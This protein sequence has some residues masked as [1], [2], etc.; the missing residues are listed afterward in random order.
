VPRVDERLGGVLSEIPTPIIPNPR[1]ERLGA[2]DLRVLV[3][4]ILLGAIGVFVAWHYYFQAFPEASINFQVSRDEALNRAK[5]FLTLQGAS[6]DGYESTI[7]FSVDDNV[8]T[9]LERTVGLEQANKLMSTEVNA[10]H[11]EIR[12]F[13]P[14]QKEEFRAD[15]N[16]EG[17]IVGYE[18]I[19]E[20]ARAGASLERE[21]AQSLAAKYLDAQYGADL[22]RYDFL[23]EESNPTERPNRRDW[24]F[25]WQLRGFRAPDNSDGAP[26]RINVSVLG[27]K[28]G[29]A[30]EFLK[31]PEAWQRDFQRMRS[32]NDL[33]ESIAI[34]P[35]MLLL[36]AAFWFIFELS[37]RGAMRWSSPLWIGIFFALLWF[38]MSISNWPEIR[39]GYD[40]NSSY[41]AF[42]LGQIAYAE[43]LSIVQALLVTIAVA[44]GEPL[45]RVSQPSRIQL[46]KSWKLPGL[47]SK[48]FFTAGII[49]VSLAAI[50]IGYVVVF[51]LVGKHVG[52]WAPQDVNFDNST[53]SI[54][55]WLGALA[56]GMYAAASE[57]F[58]F[59]LFAIPF[60]HRV[61][62]SKVIAV[63]LPA[64]MWSFLHSNYPQEPAYIRGIEIGIIGIVAGLVML[65][66]GILATLVW[67]Y[68]VDATLGSLLLL[69]SA[70]PYLRI[71]GALVAGAAFIPLA[72][73]AV[74]YFKRGGFEVRED[75]LNSAYPLPAPQESEAPTTIETVA[76]TIAAGYQSIPR[77]Y[78][79]TLIVC[80][81]A[82]IAIIAS[83]HLQ[84]VGDYAHT[85]MDARQAAAA[86]DDVMQKQ[87]VNLAMYHRATIFLSNLDSEGTD[88][89]VSKIG[90]EKTN[91]IYQQQIPEVFWRTRY[92]RDSDAEEFVVLFR[93]SGEFHSFWH[94]LDERTAGAK[95]SKD[96]AIRLAQDWIRAN[97]QIDFSAWRL[98]NSQSENPPNRVDHTFI[99]EQITP[100]AGGPKADDA[101]FKR[102]EIHVR[103]DEVSEYRTYVKLP[104]QW[105]RDAEH[106]SVLNVLQKVWPFLFF[107]G[108]AVFALTGYFR[109]L[110][111]PAATSI[112][113]RKLI[114]CGF[115]ACL[116]FVISAACNWP[117][118][119]NAYKTQI[120]FNA[121]IATIAV[122]WLIVGGIALTG[123]TFLFGLGWFFWTRAGNADKVPGWLNRSRNYYR[124]ALVFTLAGG[125]AWVG[126]EHLVSFLTQK[127][128]GASAEPVT[129]PQIDSLSPAAQSIAGTLLAA[130]ATTAII[131]ALGGFV[132]VYVR[133]RLLQALLLIGLT[134]ADMGPSESGLAFVITF[135]FTLLKF[136]IIWWIILKIVRHNLLGLFLLVAALSLL[137][138]GTSLVEQP[139]TYLRNNGVIVLGVLALL[140]IW[141]LAAW[142]RGPG[143]ATSVP[144]VTN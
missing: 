104:E 57:E 112:P 30:T 11:W 91:Q 122:G 69:R 48:E 16:P 79:M 67:H 85:S 93:A 120:P 10:W 127:L 96:D 87:N 19:V 33:I 55:P 29:G 44:P 78:M 107:A 27:D 80:G 3:A 123:V 1:I 22:A 84:K 51:Y 43:V 109:N 117:A 13:R 68:T 83:T 45:Y 138:A 99:W 58:L 72:Y 21:A 98:V 26:Y 140:L 135:L 100:L 25:T 73:C 134:L 42:T 144:V 17:R 20:E 102:M 121:F 37:R 119:L 61:T 38:F 142:L 60:F 52:V 114:W 54:F 143:D 50:H 128:A 34:I 116:A 66:W 95:L 81:I 141:P 129:F 49:G 12:F 18:H 115:I 14:Q 15:V 41:S 28:I 40:T 53:S 86:A 47:R 97:K 118:S 126:F 130:F 64:F 35:Y 2:K 103:G 31:V 77:S 70:S 137:S 8:K 131:S 63:I 113:W 24:N 124:D 89:L 32:R 71:S 106:E 9:Y 133:S 56:V 94:T 6:L 4:W 39:A 46:F 111:L 108:A 23:T 139:N 101:A 105:V 132:A 88:F 65:R 90:V 92:F 75:L 59:R 62:R 110:K 7:V 82:G 125:A 76:D 36:S 5:T 74:M 136:G